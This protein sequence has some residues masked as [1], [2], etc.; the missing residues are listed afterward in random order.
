MT[1]LRFRRA[2][3]TATPDP[4]R[5]S[6]CE[7]DETAAVGTITVRPYARQHET[8]PG[9]RVVLPGVLKLPLVNG[10]ATLADAEPG[11][12]IVQELGIAQGR[13]DGWIV[14]VPD[15]AGIVDDCDLPVIDPATLEPAV[16]AVPAW[17][18][19]TNAVAASASA[20]AGS[21]G[22]AAESAISAAESATAAAEALSDAEEARD[23]AQAAQQATMAV[24]FDVTSVATGAPGSSASVSVT[25][26]APDFDL[27]FAI[28]KGDPGGWVA[29]SVIGTGVNLDTITTPGLY[30]RGTSVGNT[31]ALGYPL[32]NWS[33]H[34][35]VSAYSTSLF[36]QVAWAYSTGNTAPEGRSFYRTY[37]AG[38]WQPWREMVHRGIVGSGD[39]VGTGF[40]EGVVTAPVGT[41]YQDTAATDG[42]WRWRKMTG[43][44]NAG[45][46][47]VEGDTGWRSI[48]SLLDATGTVLDNTKSNAAFVRRIGMTVHGR[49]WIYPVA[50]AG[51]TLMSLPMGFSPV[52]M[53]PVA[54]GVSEAA[55]GW[56]PVTITMGATTG[57]LVA[58]GAFTSTPGSTVKLSFNFTAP[59]HLSH[60]AW[61]SPRPG[62]PA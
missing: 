40:P 12:W 56:C 9:H 59:V 10:E 54:I 18:A 21:A 14:L 39:L 46:E 25:G 29:P 52:S 53:A 49:V 5:P 3:P 16:D 32:D 34:I 22:A 58:W 31:T 26:S 27:E 55:A 36:L 33:G 38:A 28:P 23:A 4:N 30:L 50:G 47:V 7:A 20:A 8:T 62:S 51:M 42:A 19:A 48:S 2:I 61:P 13:R 60:K 6:W 35:M 45:W 17:T 1:D 43:T 37:A 15:V 57:D 24:D 41:Y 11:Y 44:G